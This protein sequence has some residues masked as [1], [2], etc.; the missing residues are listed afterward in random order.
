MI[1]IDRVS[2]VALELEGPVVERLDDAVHHQRGVCGGGVRPLVDRDVAD[3]DVVAGTGV[4][5]IAVVIVRF[6]RLAS[7]HDE[8]RRSAETRRPDDDHQDD[9]QRKRQ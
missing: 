6:H 1:E 4:E 3:H 7:H 8:H 5:Q 2:V 9:Q